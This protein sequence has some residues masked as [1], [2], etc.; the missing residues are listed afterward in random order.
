MGRRGAPVAALDVPL[1]QLA[2]VVEHA[3]VLAEAHEGPA[4]GLAQRVLQRGAPA[5]LHEAQ[6]GLDDLGALQAALVP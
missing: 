3:L 1:R 5:P 4:Q 6:G 2:G